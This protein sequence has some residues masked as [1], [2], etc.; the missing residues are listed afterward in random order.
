MTPEAALAVIARLEAQ[1]AQL[2]GENQVLQ[3]RVAALEQ[4]VAALEAKQTPPRVGQAQ[5]AT[6]GEAGGG[7]A[8]ATAGRGAQPRAQPARTD[9][10]GAACP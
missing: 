2:R 4:Q 5:Q 7:R 10:H 1:N 3:A 8:A 6:H 9:P